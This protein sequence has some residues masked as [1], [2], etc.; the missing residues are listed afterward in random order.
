MTKSLSASKTLEADSNN[1]LAATKNNLK[2]T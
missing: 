1:Q 2:Q